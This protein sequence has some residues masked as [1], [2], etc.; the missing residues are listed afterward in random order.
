[1]PTSVIFF[2][3]PFSKST[4]PL[5]NY[6]GWEAE[7]LVERL[8]KYDIEYP[9]YKV[10]WN[11][12]LPTWDEKERHW[13]KTRYR[14]EEKS[15]YEERGPITSIQVA[16]DLWIKRIRFVFNH[17]FEEWRA[18]AGSGGAEG[19]VPFLKSRLFGLQLTYSPWKHFKFVW[20]GVVDNISRRRI[21]W[22][23]KSEDCKR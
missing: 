16:T 15:A 14:W 21:F 3:L 22:G 18:T 23:R 1:M 5:E 19:E 10:W 7:R 2:S 11:Q 8:K 4:P 13:R 9:D 20:V 6:T 12:P 17:T